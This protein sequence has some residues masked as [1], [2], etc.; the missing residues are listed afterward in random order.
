MQQFVQG[1]IYEWVFTIEV[2]MIPI[3]A[4]FTGKGVTVNGIE[5]GRFENTTTQKPYLLSKEGFAKLQPS[6]WDETKATW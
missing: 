1:E 3:Q 5:F 4:T 6:E 2:R